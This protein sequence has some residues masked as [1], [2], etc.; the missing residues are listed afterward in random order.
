MKPILRYYTIE[1]I[2]YFILVLEERPRS[3]DVWKK[4]TIPAM[5]IS[6]G[7]FAPE[8]LTR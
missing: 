2:D 8:V 4:T 1:A 5:G 6:G 3:G 7:F